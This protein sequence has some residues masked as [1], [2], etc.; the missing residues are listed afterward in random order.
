MG[1]TF[2]ENRVH[3]VSVQ[4]MSLNRLPLIWYLQD[5]QPSPQVIIINLILKFIY[6]WI[7]QVSM[8]DNTRILFSVFFFLLSKYNRE[9]TC[10][11]IYTYMYIS[12]LGFPGG[13]V[14]KNLPA[15]AGDTRHVGLIPGLGRS[16]G[17]GN[18]NPLQYSC[19]ENPM[20]RGAWR[21]MVHS[22]TK[23]QTWLERLSTHAVS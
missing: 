17:R 9:D 10:M 1:Q 18:G 22:L 13:S 8:W 7:F 19:L 4:P 23:S 3:G 5:K 6:K 14:V 20:D 11:L 16:P 21:A 12:I 2:R 15:N